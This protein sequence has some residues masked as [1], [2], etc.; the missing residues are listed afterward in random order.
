MS[1]P[2]TNVNNR[3]RPPGAPVSGSAPLKPGLN[4]WDILIVMGLFVAWLLD[5][6][7]KDI[8]R[9]VGQHFPW[10]VARTLKWPALV[11]E[12]TLIEAVVCI[13]VAIV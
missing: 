6:P 10:P 4:V 13:P 12:R 1:G 7:H 3:Y 5:Y 2:Q 9:F 8:S 11:L